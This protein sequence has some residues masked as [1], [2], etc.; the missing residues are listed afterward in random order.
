MPARAVPLE[1]GRLRLEHRHLAGRA[2]RR[3]VI[4]NRSSPAASS[5]SPQAR[6]QARVRVDPDAQ[7][8]ARVHRVRAAG[9]RRVPS[10]A[11]AF[12]VCMRRSSGRS[13]ATVRC[14]GRSRSASLSLARSRARRARRAARATTRTGARRVVEDRGADLDGARR[15]ASDELERVGAGADAAHADDRDVRAAPRAPA[16]RA[17]GDRPDRR[18]GQPAGDPA[19]RR[20]H[21]VE[22]D[23][24][25][26]SSV[27]IIDSPSAPA[28]THR[29]GDRRRCR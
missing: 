23:A 7:L 9:Y 25:C 18:A 5:S 10:Q 27:L 13:T 8:A 24:P 19:E 6:Q 21:R 29:L 15:P 22:V 12:L 11:S 28:S 20:A 16:R 14:G 3:T 26:P 1:E 4:A 17:H 2:P